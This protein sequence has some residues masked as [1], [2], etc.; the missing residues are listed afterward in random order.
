MSSSLKNKILGGEKKESDRNQNSL[1]SASPGPWY[2]H[3]AELPRLRSRK[4]GDPGP[5]G[6]AGTGDAPP[7]RDTKRNTQTNSKKMWEFVDVRTSAWRKEAHTSQSHQALSAEDGDNRQAAGSTDCFQEGTQ[8]LV[9]AKIHAWRLP[10]PLPRALAQATFLNVC[11]SETQSH[12]QRTPIP[13]SNHHGR[14]ACWPGTAHKSVAHR[15]PGNSSIPS[16]HTY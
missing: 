7:R 2:G 6:L 13:L 1:H 5:E 12:I 16:K 8:Q 4:K 3:Q 9:G 11:S 15:A 14:G 10:S